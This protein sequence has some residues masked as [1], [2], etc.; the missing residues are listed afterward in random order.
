VL[1]DQRSRLLDTRD[2]QKAPRRQ[3]GGAL[4]PTDRSELSSL[5]R[6]H[7]DLM[8]YTHIDYAG[9]GRVKFVFS[10]TVVTLSL[11]TDATFEDI[12]R[13]LGDLKTSRHGN[14]VAIDVTLAREARV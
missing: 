6:D 8:H 4:L 2:N 14:P 12:A 11:A 13:T 10:D 3:A 9:D 7:G 1:R 5:Q